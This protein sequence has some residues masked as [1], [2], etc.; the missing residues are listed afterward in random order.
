[1]LVGDEM[2]KRAGRCRHRHEDE[3]AHRA[4]APCQRAAEWQQPQHIE[5]DVAEIGVQQRIGDEG[6]DLGSRSARKEDLQRA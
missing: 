4:E 6:P 3:E 1:M 5:K 2:G